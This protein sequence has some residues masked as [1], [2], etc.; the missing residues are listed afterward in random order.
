MLL[1]L[2]S[3]AFA[4]WVQRMELRQLRYFA[5][6]AELLNFTRAAERLRVAQPALSR[7]I[8]NLEHELGVS[9]LERDSRRVALTAA[10]HLFLQDIREIL[11]QIEGAEARIKRFQ[12]EARQTV[13]LGFAPSLVGD[14]LPAIIHSLAETHPNLEIA[15][16]DL[17]N[18]DMLTGIRDRELDAALLPASAVPRSEFFAVCPLHEIHHAVVFPKGHRLSA[19][20]RVPVAELSRENLIAYDRRHYPDY[21]NLLR[22]IY[23]AASLPLIASAEVDGGGSLLASV[24]AGQGVAIVASTLQLTAPAAVEF[25]PLHPTGAT[26]RLALLH[27]RDLAVRTKTALRKACQQACGDCSPSE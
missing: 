9:L 16:H 25:R 15:L 27:H 8:R 19:L 7:Q 4:A 6:T 14:Q 24:Q 26:F 22:E 17:S 13:K 12:R 18:A 20:K 23:G 5:T 1:G 3:D 10:G 11:E 21:W 2:L